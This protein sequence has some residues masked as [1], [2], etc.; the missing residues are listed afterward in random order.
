MSSEQVSQTVQWL[1]TLHLT[2][3]YRGRIGRRAA[4]GDA[5]VLLLTGNYAGD[6]MNFGLAVKQLGDEGIDARYLVV[7]DDIASAPPEESTKRRDRR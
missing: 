1:A 6:V 2:V 3:G 4:H 7:T 5:G